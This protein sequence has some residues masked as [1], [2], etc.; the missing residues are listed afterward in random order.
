MNG[1]AWQSVLR[2]QRDDAT[3]RYPAEPLLRGSPHSAVRLEV[4]S[5][6]ATAAQPVAGSIGCLDLSVF[7]EDDSAPKESEPQAAAS[8]VSDERRRDV[9]IAGKLRPRNPLDDGVIDDVE[10][11]AILVADPDTCASIR[12]D[13]VN[14]AR[15][16]ASH[17][18][19]STVFETRD[20]C[21]RL[22]PT[23]DH[24]RLPPVIR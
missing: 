3:V 17:A 23:R 20:T 13:G 14:P 18:V 24:D 11:A 7:Q 1:L 2:R 4:Q 22:R 5:H 19:K 16:H 12:S 10:Q 21:R 8:P 9:S 15:R 6:D